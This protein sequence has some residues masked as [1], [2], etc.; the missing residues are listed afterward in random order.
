[1]SL[2][3]LLLAFALPARCD[4]AAPQKVK[5]AAEQEAPEGPA[6]TELIDIPTAN[7]YDYGALASRGRFT[8][9]G[10]TIGDLTIGVLQSFNVGA[11]LDVDRLIGTGSPVKVREPAV[12]LKW[13]FYDGSRL[14]PALAVG[15]DGQGYFYN[16]QKKEYNEQFRGLYLVGS[17]EIGIPGLWL[18]PGLNISDFNTNAVYGFVGLAYNIK[19]KVELMGEWD[20]IQNFHDSR[21]NTGVRFYVT[22][23]FTIN[24]AVREIAGTGPFSDGTVHANERVVILKYIGN[25]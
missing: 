20:N 5:L 21:A 7:V 22:P 24:V 10:G 16:D 12:E 9:G 13:R 17:Q 23:Q 1:M 19:Q 4:D 14:F 25:F 6:D 18:H 11:S 15:F 2:L 3:L 8:S